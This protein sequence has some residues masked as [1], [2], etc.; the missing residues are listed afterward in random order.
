M[1]FVSPSRLYN[2]LQ[3]DLG[4]V[5]Q[6]IDRVLVIK[7]YYSY[8]RF[9]RVTIRIGNKPVPAGTG[10]VDLATVAPN[11]VCAD[12]AGNNVQAVMIRCY[13][14]LFGRYVTFQNKISTQLE[15]DEVYVY[16]KQ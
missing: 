7:R 3:I 12:Y 9:K 13:N 6:N 5:L 8:T 10:A 1:A 2:W 16:T 14:P 11:P 15:M 4:S